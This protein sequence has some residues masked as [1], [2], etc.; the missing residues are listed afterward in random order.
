MHIGHYDAQLG[1][2]LRQIAQEL[3]DWATLAEKNKLG[4]NHIDRMK[5]ESDLLT[6]LINNKEL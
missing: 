1:S 4:P 2:K 5:L 3:K 6:R